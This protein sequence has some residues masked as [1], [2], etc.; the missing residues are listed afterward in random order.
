MKNEALKVTIFCELGLCNRTNSCV[1]FFERLVA[2]PYCELISILFN[3]NVL[4]NSMPCF[5]V[6]LLSI[7]FY[8]IRKRQIGTF[9]PDH[10]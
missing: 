10:A 6:K 2:H 7:L 9:L 3:S 1:W 5:F 8:T 4:Y